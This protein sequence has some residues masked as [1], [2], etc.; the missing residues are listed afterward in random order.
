MKHII[1]SHLL[2]QQVRI[3]LAG[4]GGGG[5]QVLTGLARLHRALLALGHPGGLS[6]SAYDPDK[7]TSG[8]VGRQLFADA[9]MGLN[10]A[11]VLIY[12]LNA[13]YGLNWSAVPDYFGPPGKTHE[14]I[15]HIVISCVDT[16]QARRDI[17][18]FVRHRSTAYWMDLGNKQSDGQVILGEPFS[19]HE[20][21]RERPMRLPTVTDLYPDILDESIPDD[22]NAPSCSLA[23]SLEHQDLWIG[24]SVAT[25]ALQLLWTLF[26]YGG[27]N[28]HGYFINLTSGMTVPMPVDADAWK[29]FKPKKKR[30]TK[31]RKE[32]ANA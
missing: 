14:Q 21:R 22:N 5:S 7:V 18:H 29:R 31:P 12:R 20:K 25:Y 30:G 1:Q 11:E 28:H 3:T 24:Q 6:V 13:F 8:N 9:D 15:P 23:E 26:R 32:S 17:D 10:K 4:C 2:S 16:R 19:V 27:V